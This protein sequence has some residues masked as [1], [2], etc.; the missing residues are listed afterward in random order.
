MTPWRRTFLLLFLL[1]LLVGGG[2]A[3]FLY[4]RYRI[5][6]EPEWAALPLETYDGRP[7]DAAAWAGRPTLVTFWQ[8]W[9]PPCRAEMPHL[10]AV[11]EIMAP[12]GLRAVVVS[13][14]PMPLLLRHM[15]LVPE[16]LERLRVPSLQ[17]LDVY[18]FP[19]TV[20]YDA[21]GR[22]VFKTTGVLDGT[23]LAVA[24]DFRRRLGASP[25]TGER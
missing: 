19:T 12:E 5:A 8:T 13:D 14:E 1:S 7:V 24:E 4:D 15:D 2:V 10:A 17:A 9:C 21:Q 20:L 23:P 22:V 16:R 3:W 18:T 25:G 6:P 11:A